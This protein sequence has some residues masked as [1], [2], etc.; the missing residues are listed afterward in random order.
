MNRLLF[1][2]T[3]AAD[4]DISCKG[5]FFRRNS[6]VLVNNRLIID[7]GAHILILPKAS[8]IRICIRMFRTF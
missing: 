8:D 4:W 3:G 6:A 7:C 1:L 5:D 2:G